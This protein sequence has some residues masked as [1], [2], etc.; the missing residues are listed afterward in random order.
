[1]IFSIAIEGPSHTLTEGRKKE[2]F[3]I[4]FDGV[5]FHFRAKELVGTVI[6]EE[7]D[8]KQAYE[9]ARDS[10][11]KAV[12]KL[13]YIYNQKFNI[14]TNGYYYK[15]EPE[16]FKEH[17]GKTLTIS[18]GVGV[19]E[20]FETTASKINSIKTEKKKALDKALGYYNMAQRSSNPI[21]ANA[22]YVS[23]MEAIVRVN[24]GINEIQRGH[25]KQ[26]IKRVLQAKSKNFDENAFNTKFETVYGKMRSASE[27]GHID[28]KDETT[29]NNA[30]DEYI[31]KNQ[32]YKGFTSPFYLT[33]LLLL[34]LTVVYND[35]IL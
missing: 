12:P 17:V 18:F 21:Q 35:E 7:D 16:A 33:F 15:E 30:K 20:N 14:V 6:I 31:N 19:E 32:S 5:V 2:E 1:M 11:D 8:E 34:D 24:T 29:L 9:K 4:K 13:C 23:C 25:L 22:L 27:H 3:K 10:I 26:E 28:L